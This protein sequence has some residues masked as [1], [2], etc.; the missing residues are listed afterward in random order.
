MSQ[1][2]EHRPRGGSQ[3]GRQPCDVRSPQPSPETVCAF[4]PTEFCVMWVDVY[5][6]EGQEAPSMPTL[7][8]DGSRHRI[9]VPLRAGAPSEADL[10][11][12]KA[13]VSPVDAQTAAV[14]VPSAC[15]RAPSPSTQRLPILGRVTKPLAQRLRP[16][17]HQMGVT[18]PPLQRVV[19]LL[20]CRDR[21]GRLGGKKGRV[22]AKLGS[23]IFQSALTAASLGQPWMWLRLFPA[24]M[25]KLSAAVNHDRLNHGGAMWPWWVTVRCPGWLAG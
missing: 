5:N 20:L 11:S 22:V 16:C 7:P 21:A 17:I 4:S 19:T 23:L 15:V 8:P 25:R 3:G 6:Q 18:V 1:W 13:V 2:P 10:P 9:P 24:L 14:G 12:S